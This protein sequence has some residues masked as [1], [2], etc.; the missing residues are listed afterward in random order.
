METS[1]NLSIHG[2][3]VEWTLFQHSLNKGGTDHRQLHIKFI[4]CV[5]DCIKRVASRGIQTLKMIKQEGLFLSYHAYLCVNTSL[6]AI[7]FI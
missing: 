7:P 3:T 5:H 4:L 2:V 6:H 1:P